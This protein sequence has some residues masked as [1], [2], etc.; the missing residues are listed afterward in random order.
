MDT[1]HTITTIRAGTADT[2][3]VAG[4]RNKD[5][6]ENGK[7]EERRKSKELKEEE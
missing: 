5:E 3:H 7:R 2:K 6:E 4:E 1:H